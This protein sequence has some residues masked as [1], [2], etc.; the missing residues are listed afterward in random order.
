MVR[1]TRSGVTAAAAAAATKNGIS[2]PRKTTR[3][4]RRTVKTTIPGSISSSS[5]PA[6]ESTLSK[7][8]T[9]TS[10]VEAKNDDHKYNAWSKHANSSP[11]PSFKF[12]TE[13]QCRRSHDILEKMHG[14]TVRKNF[15]EMS[16]PEQH[17]PHVMDA[18]VVAQLSQA[19]AWSSAQRAMKS[20]ASVYGSTFAYQK[21]LDGGI[22]KLQDALRP[23]GMQNRKAKMLT[24]L[25][26]DV[27]KRHG[28]WDLDFM[29]K[30]SDDEAMKE[31]LQYHGI[32]K[33]L[34]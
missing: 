33:A 26:L 22:E 10:T 8:Q 2:K 16:N 34:L 30:L 7:P 13:E 9:P 28:K 19:T 17:Y 12:A 29:F 25:L 14:D 21:I 32:G 3:P 20:M 5:N 1:T 23:G 18:L 4:E 27:K 15:A 24:K 6:S 31:V 11:F